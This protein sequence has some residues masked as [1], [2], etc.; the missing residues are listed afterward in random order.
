MTRA[1]VKAIHAKVNSLLSMCDLDTPLNGLLLHSDTLC[2]LSYGGP[3]DPY[4]DG[5]GSVEVGQESS[6]EDDEGE[7][8]KM[9]KDFPGGGT[10]AG[11][12]GT[13]A[14]GPGTPN[15][16][17]ASGT[18]GGTNRYRE[19]GKH[20]LPPQRQRSLPPRATAKT[21]LRI[22]HPVSPAVA[23]TVPQGTGDVG[24]RDAGPHQRQHRLSQRYYRQC[25]SSFARSAVKP[26]PL[27]SF[28]TKTI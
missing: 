22:L 23:G 25:G 16:P 13:T 7:E 10:T 6:Q 20:E 12:S 27:T 14:P 5:Q 11:L 24:R 9:E 4:E 3:D 17:H 15:Q 18:D 2:V 1:R 21:T 26:P 19:R 8:E 28:R